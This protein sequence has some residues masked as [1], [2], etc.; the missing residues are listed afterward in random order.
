MGAPVV[1]SALVEALLAAAAVLVV[2]LVAVAAAEPVS[3]VRLV[4]AEA[5]VAA[6]AVAAAAAAAET[7]VLV[8]E[9]VRV[10]RTI[11]MDV[12]AKHEWERGSNLPISQLFRTGSFQQSEEYTF[13]GVAVNDNVEILTLITLHSRYGDKRLEIILLR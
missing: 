11:R 13:S 10:A 7:A 5:V 9:S 1:A 12:N 8:G 4:L 2:S 6:A 3:V